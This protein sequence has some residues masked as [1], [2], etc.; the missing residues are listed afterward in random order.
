[1]RAGPRSQAFSCNGGTRGR[2]APE[3]RYERE[4]GLPVSTGYSGESLEREGETSYRRI[5]VSFPLHVAAKLLDQTIYFFL[6]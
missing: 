3:E 5:F 4:A 2:D 6:S 1:M